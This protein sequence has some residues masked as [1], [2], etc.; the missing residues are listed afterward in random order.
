MPADVPSWPALLEQLLQGEALS[1]IQATK[2]MQAWLAEDLTPVQTGGFLAGLRA[3]GL[4]AEELAAMAA[5][6]REACPLPCP[7]PDLLMVDTCGTGGDG[8]DTFNI[9]TAVAFTAASCGVKV[10]KHG[11]RS[12]S[13][14]VG[15]ADVLEGL[16][17]NL[18]APL[19]T[20]VD[21]ITGTGVTFL[22]APA[23]H[24]A[25]VNL[26]P[27]R[28]SLG[29]R[30]VFNLL[31]PL[32]NPLRPQ[33]QVLG[34]AKPDLLDPMAGALLRLGVDRSI[35]VH[36]AGG[37]DE[38]SLAGDNDLRL[39]EG[40]EIVER[41]LRPED[42]GLTSA[43][44]ETLRGGD[45]LVNQTILEAVL[46]GQGSAAQRDAVAFNTAL[47]LW[48]SGLETDLGQAAAQ[49]VAALDAGLPWQRL[50]ELRKVLADGDGE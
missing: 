28:K 34:V 20:V 19:K 12:A 39:I 45:L 27:L 23:W 48:S 15:S 46:R 14:K 37:L 35:V 25:L 24:P 44:L 42:L 30:T 6:L 11:N 13:G 10:A 17:L 47:V 33:A 32:V 9:S 36:G 5:V 41:L 43:P 1:A 16:G 31:G 22:F 26:A 7:R 29:V 8:A 2:L 49:A 3:K 38:A 18:K 40:G 50:V 4:V 21:A